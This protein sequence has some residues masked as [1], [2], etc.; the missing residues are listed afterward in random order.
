M[1]K[2]LVV[3]NAQAPT[4]QVLEFKRYTFNVKKSIE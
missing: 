2:M 3:G 1:T 4:G